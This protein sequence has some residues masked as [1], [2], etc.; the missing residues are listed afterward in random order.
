MTKF[1]ALRKLKD[2]A[3]LH[4]SYSQVFTYLGCS[5]KYRF[6]YVENRPHERTSSTL[7][8]GTALHSA[9]ERY[10]K[11]IKDKGVK[12]PLNIL[13]DLVEASL[14]LDF[15]MA[16]IPVQFKQEAPDKP[17]LISLGKSLIK[18]FYESIDLTGYRIVDV[19]MP[20]SATLYDELAKPTDLKLIGVIDLLLMSD[21]G[22]IVIVDNKSSAKPKSQSTVDDDLQFSAYSY[23]LASNRMTFAKADIQCRMDVLRKLKTP[24]FEQYHTIRS[25][26]NR[27][28]FAKLASAVLK[29]IESRVFIPN[30]SWLC[31]DCQFINACKSW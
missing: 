1:L 17:S 30:N 20:L 28:R 25:A 19:E 15:D 27:R 31:S 13:E 18:T 10:Y 16:E 4:I 7:F 6:Q 21:M 9:I 23:L 12:E 11:T 29:G 14:A 8:L 3:Y 2:E 26:E 24:K 22:E 5:Q